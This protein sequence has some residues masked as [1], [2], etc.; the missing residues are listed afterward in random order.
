MEVMGRFAMIRKIDAHNTFINLLGGTGILGFLAF[1][2]Y[3]KKVFEVYRNLPS[4]IL[5]RLDMGPFLIS[6]AGT[7]IWYMVNTHPFSHI[8]QTTGLLLDLYVNV[9]NLN[10]EEPIDSEYNP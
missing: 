8:V 4:K 2:Y 9:Y 7:Q 5:K 1:L 3:M 6:V 10:I